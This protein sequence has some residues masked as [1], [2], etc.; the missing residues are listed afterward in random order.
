MV[1]KFLLSL[2][3][4]IELTYLVPSLVRII[5]YS[6]FVVGGEVCARSSSNSMIVF[7]NSLLFSAK[8]SMMLL[9]K[10]VCKSVIFLSAGLQLCVFRLIHFVEV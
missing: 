1:D 4:R 9:S 10:I 2:H 7:S 8:L 3:S 5:K 6:L